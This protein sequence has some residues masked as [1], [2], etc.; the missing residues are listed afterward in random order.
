MSESSSHDSFYDEVSF[1]DLQFSNYNSSI[2]AI[3]QDNC[4]LQLTDHNV[5]QSPQPLAVDRGEESAR[6]VGRMFTS[7][8]SISYYE[9]M[10]HIT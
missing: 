8:I 9:N 6:V 4:F 3:T 1:D 5:T 2:Q 10:Y 7:L